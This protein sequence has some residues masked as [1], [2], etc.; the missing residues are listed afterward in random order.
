[1]EPESFSKGECSSTASKK[2]TSKP[3]YWR[4][5]YELVGIDSTP[6]DDDQEAVNVVKYWVNVMD[7][8]D[9]DGKKKV[10]EPRNAS[11]V[12]AVIATWKC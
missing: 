8:T 4:R 10:L 2:P 11:F 9:E 12:Y 6:I 1:M 5:C 7:V 3:S